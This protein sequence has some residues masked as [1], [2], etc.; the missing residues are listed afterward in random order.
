MATPRR[1]DHVKITA[2]TGRV[3]GGPLDG[4]TGTVV[5]VDTGR[6]PVVRVR[7]D[8]PGPAPVVPVFADETEPTAAP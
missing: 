6:N 2:H 4:R 3:D 1:R 8:G 5:D 7:L